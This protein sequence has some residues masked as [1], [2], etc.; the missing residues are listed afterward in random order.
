MPGFGEDWVQV[1]HEGV[2]IQA[3]F[4]VAQV[5]ADAAADITGSWGIVIRIKTDLLQV[6]FELQTL[7][8]FGLGPGLQ[9]HIAQRTGHLQAIDH[10]HDLVRQRRQGMDQRGQ[11]REVE[12][13][14]LHL[15]AFIGSV[16]ARTLLQLQ[17]RLP[18]S[19]ADVHGQ[20]SSTTSK[21]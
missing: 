16:F 11:G 13:I 14:G 5:T 20:E 21:P 10:G 7:V 8:A 19:F 1:Q 2:G 18:T 17:V 9:P 3:Q 15:P 12:A 4:T 6:G